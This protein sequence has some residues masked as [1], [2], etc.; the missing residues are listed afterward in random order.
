MTYI[1]L[2][3]SVFSLFLCGLNLNSRLSMPADHSVYIQKEI[4]FI[5]RKLFKSHVLKSVQ[6]F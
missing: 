1:S 6:R 4:H 5:K 2:A 3:V